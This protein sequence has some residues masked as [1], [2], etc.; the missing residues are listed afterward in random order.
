MDTKI[1]KDFENLIQNQ[2]NFICNNYGVPAFELCCSVR[3]WF[4][5][6]LKHVQPLFEEENYCPIGLNL[7]IDIVAADIFQSGVKK[8]FWNLLTESAYKSKTA[9]RFFKNRKKPTM[10]ST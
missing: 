6:C 5:T 7:Y 3:D 2:S 10:T 4:E 9:T 8:L 1:F